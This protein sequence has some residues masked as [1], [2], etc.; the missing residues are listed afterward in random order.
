MQAVAALL[1]AVVLQQS[2]DRELTVACWNTENLFDTRRDTD[3]NGEPV[4]SEEEL[5]KKMAKLAEVIKYLKA[6]IVGLTE[7]ENQGVLRRLVREHLKDDGYSHFMLVDDTDPRGIDAAMIAKRPFTAY[8]FEIPGHT[9]G[10]LACRFTIA[11]EPFY[12]LVNHWKSRIGGGEDIRMACARRTVELVRDVLP[13]HE[14]RPVPTLITGDFNDDDGDPSVMSLEQAGLTNTLKSLP[15]DERWTYPW[16]D[17]SN[18][19]VHY[20]TFDHIFANAAMLDGSGVDLTAGSARVVRPKFMLRKRT[21]SGA[22]YDWVDDSYGNHLGY[23][24]HLPVVVRVASRKGVPDA[25]AK[26]EE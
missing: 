22:A 13:L 12:V 24:D 17:S 2:P 7:V 9:R 10:I 4:P 6:D 14:G 20:H 3:A 23:S 25:A 5:Q 1:L 11:G 18:K 8:S 15:S 16:W 19:K 21:I 26:R